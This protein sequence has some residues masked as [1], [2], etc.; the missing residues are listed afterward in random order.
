M[1][2][3]QILTEKGWDLYLLLE[4]QVHKQRFDRGYVKALVQDLGD[5]IIIVRN[6][7]RR[8]FILKGVRSSGRTKP[9]ILPKRE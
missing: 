8:R 1:E 6:P 5:E 3:L 4:T 9:D 2:R 7:I